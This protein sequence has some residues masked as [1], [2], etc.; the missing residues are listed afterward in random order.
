MLSMGLLGLGVVAFAGNSES[1]AD[2][3]AANPFKTHNDLLL[4]VHHLAPGFGGMFLSDDNTILYAYMLD[5]SQEEAAKQALEEVF[6]TGTPKG[7][8]FRLFRANT[9][10]SSFTIGT[11]AN[12]TQSGLFRP[13]T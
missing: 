13:F 3:K 7:G 6:G 1:S 2:Q 8:S 11:S 4:E 10:S 5:T 12:V 9:V